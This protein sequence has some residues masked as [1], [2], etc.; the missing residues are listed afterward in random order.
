MLKFVNNK[1]S[2]IGRNSTAFTYKFIDHTY[3]CEGFCKTWEN[4]QQFTNTLE[5]S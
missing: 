3:K 4:T 1:Q 2:K 5:I